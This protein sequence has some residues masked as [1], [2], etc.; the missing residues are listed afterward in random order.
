M[1]LDIAN[2]ERGKMLAAFTTYKIGGVADFFVDVRS[3]AELGAAVREARRAG[4]AYFLLGAGANILVTDKGFRGLVIHNCA[5]RFEFLNNNHLRAESG[6]IIAELIVACRDHGLSG[7][8][9]YVGIPST[10][11]GALWQNLHFLS[12]APARERTVFIAEVLES[13]TVLNKALEVKTVGPDYFKFG[14]DYS[15][16][17][18]TGDIVLDATLQLESKP[19][20]AIQ[21]VM[22]ENLA[23]RRAKQPQLEDV[24]SC[25]SVFKKIEG[26]G[27]GRLI[28]QAGLKGYRIGGAMVSPKHANYFVNLNHATAADVLALINHVQKVV[29]E[30][31]G[32]HLEPEISIVGERI[33]YRE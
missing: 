3:T 2:L 4:I 5:Q 20:E 1:P 9:H 10:V 29:K 24:A 17:R 28:D 27:A 15:T 18:D 7:L 30:K 19:K 23:W 13:A 16:L 22:D 32:Y 21:R 14:Y 33:G 26:V 12:P 6:A 25:G 31:T 8:E 11:G